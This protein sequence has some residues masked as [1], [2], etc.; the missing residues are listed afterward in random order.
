MDLKEMNI[1]LTENQKKQ[2][3]RA[4]ANGSDAKVRLNKYQI[5]NGDG[6]MFLTNRQYNKVNK[7][8]QNGR[9]CDVL[10]TKKQLQK[11]K[12]AGFLPLLIPA[13]VGAV[14]PWLLNKVFPDRQGHGEG[15]NIPGSGLVVPGRGRPMKGGGLD[16]LGRL[17]AKN[18]A[19][20][21]NNDRVLRGE[22]P[23]AYPELSG[24][25]LPSLMADNG[26]EIM[27]NNGGPISNNLRGKRSNF[28]PNSSGPTFP[29][30]YP[31]RKTKQLSN[32]F[33]HPN[34]EKYQMLE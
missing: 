1:T 20:S 34:S 17:I 23:V 22:A 5:N 21:A 11:V 2:V 32:V 13:A 33:L 6:K 15:I 30:Q 12:T 10:M 4:L 14:L 16:P 8:Y 7:A 18:A 3:A 9:G 26:V 31:N 29:L 27:A 24:S 19:I 25:G 28:S